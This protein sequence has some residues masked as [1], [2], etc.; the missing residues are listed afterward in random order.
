MPHHLG[1]EKKKPKP[2]KKRYV[3]GMWLT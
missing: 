1:N 3:P 2:A